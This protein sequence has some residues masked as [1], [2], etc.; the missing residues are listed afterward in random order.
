MVESNSHQPIL[1]NF[2]CEIQS[3]FMAPFAVFTLFLLVAFLSLYQPLFA[4]TL[5][6][7]EETPKVE[8]DS[9]EVRKID[10]SL[11]LLT[12]KTPLWQVGATDVEE[13][14]AEDMVDVGQILPG[15]SFLD[16]GSLGQA[17]PMSARGTS[18]QE[19]AISLNGMILR[20]PLNGIPSSAVL[21]IDLIETFSLRSLDG[22]SNYGAETVGGTLEIETFFPDLPQP[23]SRVQFRTGDWGYSDIGLSLGLPIT[24]SLKVMFNGS[25]QE[26]DGFFGQA[27][28][29]VD[30]RFFNT[31]VYK[32]KASLEIRLMTLLNRNEV[33]APAPTIPDLV[34]N[35]FNPRRK[36]IRFD[37]QISG[38]MR[39]LFGRNS[40][41]Q[42]R[43]FFSRDR[44]QSFGDTLLF[45]T[46]SKSFGAGLETKFQ[47]AFGE[48][49]FGGEG[50][51]DKLDS[52][53][54]HDDSDFVGH[55]FARGQFKIGKFL[56]VG[57]QVRLE[58]HSDFSANFNPSLRLSLNANSQTAW[59]GWRQTNRYPTF[60][61]RFWQ[62]P[63]FVGNPDLSEESSTAVEVG[64]ATELHQALEIKTTA[65]L[66]R[67]DDWI[68][69]HKGQTSF[70]PMNFNERKIGGVD[71]SLKWSYRTNTKVGLIGSYLFVQ[72][73]E[74]ET[75][76]QVPEYSVNTF[77]QVGR[78]MFQESFT[79]KLRATAR[80]V[81]DRNGWIYPNG[82]ALPSVQ[83]RNAKAVFDGKI[84]LLFIHTTLSFSW[85][86]I[87]D[88]STVAG[89]T[90][91]GDY[92][93]VPGFS[94]PPRTFRFGVDWQFMN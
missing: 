55:T 15:I 75:E 21:P 84:S 30:S 54:L 58:K 51:I 9:S 56:A 42:T 70:G 1:K 94:M 31:F 87:F 79:L 88:Q 46:K 67:V 68:G 12:E 34:P 52:E 77:L 3:S 18:P 45:D 64:F 85:E 41:F 35:L 90:L 11:P 93:L 80:I 69:N 71:L 5:P 37:Q 91:Q 72:D 4:Q 48:F 62:S 22:F 83:V 61:E 14:I 29:D 74:L 49:A 47:Y 24:K 40:Q 50:R 8:S 57:G 16:F 20:E 92:E 6:G 33:E 13:I 23:Y 73:S 44:R 78:P 39:G 66:N 63:F 2:F 17:S 86:N 60:A 76:L 59:L 53:Q 19:G 65:F 25:R 32:P 10:S 43:V 27:R 89:T 36:E 38:K 26:L 81:G 7:E 28:D 82:A